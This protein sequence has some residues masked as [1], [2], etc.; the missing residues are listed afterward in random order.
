MTI[1]QRLDEN[2]GTSLAGI[3]I[4]YHTERAVSAKALGSGGPGNTL[5]VRDMSKRENRKIQS[6]TVLCFMKN[7]S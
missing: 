5:G 2:E 7:K 4:K 6:L 1:E 3:R